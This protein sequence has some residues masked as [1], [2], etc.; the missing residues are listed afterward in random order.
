MSCGLLRRSDLHT[1]S[2]GPSIITVIR[3]C[4]LVMFIVSANESDRGCIG[5]VLVLYI[6]FFDSVL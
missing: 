1:K 6:G 2:A 4:Y 3:Q 5:I